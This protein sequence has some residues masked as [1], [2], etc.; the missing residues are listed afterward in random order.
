M[1]FTIKYTE[2][3]TEKFKNFAKSKTLQETIELYSDG[4]SVNIHTVFTGLT[5]YVIDELINQHDKISDEE[6]VIYQ[7][8]EEI[9]VKY[10]NFPDNTEEGDF[11]EAACVC[12]LENLLNW[13]SGGDISYGR[14]IPYLGEKSKE[15]CRAWDEFTGVKSPGLW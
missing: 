8:I 7:F 15:Y 10:S 3:L 13:A 9:R 14:F 2:I 4:E 11:D 12:F 1:V 6:L 5:H